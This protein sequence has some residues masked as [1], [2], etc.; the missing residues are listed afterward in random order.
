[1]A[2]EK[3][4]IGLTYVLIILT[5][6]I[7]YYYF[8]YKTKNEMNEEFNGNIPTFWLIIIPIASIY[9]LY[10]YAECFALNVK[11]ENDA[12]LY[13]ILIWFAGVIITPWLV[14]S[15]L[16]KIIDNP[17]LLEYRKN[18]TKLRYCP[19]CGRRIPFD[20]N[21]CPYCAKKFEKFL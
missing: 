14:Q 1:M 21:V 5:L 9:W 19:N 18:A 6:G 20:A 11:R 13:F 2:L 7:Y 4:E 8:L 17:T 10:K 15:E 3:R 12:V 16:N